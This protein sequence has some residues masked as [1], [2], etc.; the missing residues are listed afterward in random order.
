MT[1][2]DH[3]RETVDESKTDFGRAFDVIVFVS[4]AISVIAVI[5]ESIPSVAAVYGAQLHQL[6]WIVTIWFTLEYVMR[7]ITARKPLKYVTGFYG[8]VDLLAILPTYLSLLFIESQALIVF[9]AFRFLRIFRVFKLT[10]F[11]SEAS[12]LAVALKASRQKIT[13]FM[14][15]VLAIALVMGT[16]MYLVEG[17]KSGFD[18]IPAGIYWAIVTMTT[19]GYGDLAPHTVMGKFVASVLMLLG[20]SIIAIPTGIVSVEIAEASRSGKETRICP[21]CS[22]PGHTSDAVFCRF[23][24]EKL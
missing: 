19:V 16:L 18:S 7:L 20:Y 21:K 12:V 11:V 2:L 15:T 23:C 24:G 13:V 10:R 1:W 9:R 8:I 3:L 22:T 14:L 6:E 17:G 5:L 4:I